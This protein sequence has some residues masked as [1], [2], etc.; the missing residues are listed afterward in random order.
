MSDAMSNDP[1]LPLQSTRPTRRSLSD[2]AAEAGHDPLVTTD[3]RDRALLQRWVAGDTRAGDRLISHYFAGIRGYF[4]RRVPHEQEDLVQQT[5]MTLQQAAPKYRGE[6]SVRV[7][8]YCIARNML[9]RHFTNERRRPNFDPNFDS[10]ALVGERR[11]SSLL[12]EQQHL[13][14]LL[15][16]LEELPVTQ[17]DLLELY[18]WQ[19]LTGTEIKDLF[20]VS[21]GSVRGKIQR[22]LAKLRKLYERK[23]ALPSPRLV[24]DDSRLECMLAELA[25]L[26]HERTR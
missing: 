18:Y 20:A 13:H 9:R 14:A 2:A 7:F 6:G 24:A 17:Q 25:T 23:L 15:D 12:A 5:F 3:Q 26:V 11:L 22:T 19:G 1:A 10:L 21:E 4:L 8:I 16:A